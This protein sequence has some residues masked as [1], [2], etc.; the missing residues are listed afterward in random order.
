MNYL[1]SIHDIPEFA[2]ANLDSD[3]IYIPTPII[4][5]LM[6][7]LKSKG[8]LAYS[9][10][11]NR[12]RE[13]LD[14][15]HKGYDEAGNTFIYFTNKELGE[16]LNCNKDSVISTKK[17][18]HQL[19]LIDEVQQGFGEPN[20]IYITDNILK[21][22]SNTQL[23]KYIKEKYLRINKLREQA[24]DLEAEIDEWFTKKDLETLTYDSK[25][26][27]L[28]LLSG[29][30]RNFYQSED[31]ALMALDEAYRQLLIEHAHDS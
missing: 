9:V 30:G 15:I 7:D 31:E 8:A 12:L 2:T 19:N 1:T 16:V 20:R 4:N 28:P 6:G 27:F 23:P 3:Q 17:I 24:L 26:N 25:G 13:P 21:Y 5:Q 29:D 11:L 18:L 10:L 14:F 22:Y